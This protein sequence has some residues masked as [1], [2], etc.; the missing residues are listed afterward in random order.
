MS[1]QRRYRPRPLGDIATTV[2]TAVD[3]VKDPYLQELIC[4]VQQLKSINDKTP[5]VPCPKTMTTSTAGV[6]LRKVV[7]V[8]RGYV[9]AEQHRWVYAVAAVGIIG[10]PMLIGYSLARKG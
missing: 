1:Y 5:V 6:G 3:V 7:P 9:Y 4:N 2:S 8:V 10:L